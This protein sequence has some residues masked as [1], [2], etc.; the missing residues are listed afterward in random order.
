MLMV[1]GGKVGEVLLEVGAELS[2]GVDLDQF[3]LTARLLTIEVSHVLFRLC[4][5]LGAAAAHIISTQHVL[6]HGTEEG[7]RVL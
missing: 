6:H 4:T 3:L 7:R 2:V 1:D 5:D